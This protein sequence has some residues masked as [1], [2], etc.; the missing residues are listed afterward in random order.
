MGRRILASTFMAS[1]FRSRQRH[2]AALA[3]KRICARKTTLSPAGLLLRSQ[4]GTKS[5]RIDPWSSV[6]EVTT[7]LGVARVP[8]SAAWAKH[9]SGCASSLTCCTPLS[10]SPDQAW[11]QHRVSRLRS[12]SQP[13]KIPGCKGKQPETNALFQSAQLSLTLP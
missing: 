12:G 10:V 8:N 1:C 6:E 9:L 5:V 2:L 3:S 11:P 7:H 4:T 13:E